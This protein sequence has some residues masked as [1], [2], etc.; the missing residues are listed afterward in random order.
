MVDEAGAGRNLAMTSTKEA[1]DFFKG[2]R[3][4]LFIL[5]GQDGSLGDNFG[6]GLG[7]GCNEIR[8]NGGFFKLISSLVLYKAD[9]A[10][11]NIAM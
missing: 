11:R 4:S 3:Y 7:D 9:E 2:W 8:G 10:A 6:I 5:S 1:I